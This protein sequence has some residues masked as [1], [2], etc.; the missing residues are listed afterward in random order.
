M[1]DEIS[2]DNFEKAKLL[3]DC[4]IDGNLTYAIM[5]YPDGSLHLSW[6]GANK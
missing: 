5:L 1:S 2:W 6:M 3:I 4:W